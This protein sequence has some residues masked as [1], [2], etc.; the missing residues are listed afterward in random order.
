M[1]YVFAAIVIILVIIG[2]LYSPKKKENIQVPVTVNPIQTNT[3]PKVTI[4]T[5][6]GVIEIEL[7]PTDAPKTVENFTTLAKKNFYDGVIFHRV[8]KGFMIQ[9][10]DPTGTGRGGPG[11]TF[12][13]E[14]N[15]AAESYKAGYVRGTVAMANAGPN[16]NGSQFFIMHADYPL[17]HNYTIFGRVTKGLEIV[18][19]IANSPTD[20][21]DK[22]LQ[23]I[24]MQKVAVE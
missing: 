1:K 7:F 3:M 21:N 15:P 10:G 18:D 2:V 16:T 19:M 14:L 11:Y 6:K 5:N 20:V 8:I 9:G 17:P 4:Q 22:P 12:A 13:D 23:D 24:I